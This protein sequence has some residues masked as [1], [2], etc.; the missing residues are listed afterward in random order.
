MVADMMQIN[1]IKNVALTQNASF[2]HV[3]GKR[4]AVLSM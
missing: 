3:V 1:G 4:T 2:H